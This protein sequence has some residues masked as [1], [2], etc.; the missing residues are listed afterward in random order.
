MLLDCIAA[1][2]GAGTVGNMPGWSV[3]EPV[4]NMVTCGCLL[5]RCNE[6]EKSGARGFNL[7]ILT[8]VFTDADGAIAVCA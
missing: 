7:D 6:L 2:G 5:L 4:L 3:A 8:V 1:G